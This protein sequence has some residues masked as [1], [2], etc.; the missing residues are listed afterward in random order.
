M[1][2]DVTTLAAYDATLD[3]VIFYRESRDCI[4]YCSFS[5]RSLDGSDDYPFRFLCSIESSLIHCVVDVC[6]GLRPCLSLEIVNKILLGFFC[7]HSSDGFKFGIDFFLQCIVL[8]HLC[9][10]LGLESINLTGLG[11]ELVLLASKLALKLVELVLAVLDSVFTV[12]ELIV[13]FVNLLV[14]LTLELQ[15]FFL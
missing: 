9:V 4:F 7:R 2:P 3:F 14:I 12:T 13:L 8:L 15:V 1:S 6:L 5:C 10:Q 11:V